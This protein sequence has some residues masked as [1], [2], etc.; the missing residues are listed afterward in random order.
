MQMRLLCAALAAGFALAGCGAH[1]ETE[2]LAAGVEAPSRIIVVVMENKEYGEIIGSSEAP[3][4]NALA[5][6]YS[7]PRRYHG[8]RH[9]SLPNYIALVAGSTLGIDSNCTRCHR[10]QRNL[11]DQFE[12]AG[13]SWRAYMEG[14]PRRCYR[15]ARHGRYAKKHNPFAYFDTVMERRARCRKIVPGTELQRDI[16]AGTLPEF[17][18]VKPDL[19]ND[20]HDC[21]IRHGDDYLAGLIP[22]LLREVGPSG[23][24]LLVW[25]EGSSDR[26]CCGGTARGGRVAAVVAGPRVRRGSRPRADLSHYSSLRTIEDFFGLG[27]LRLAGARTTRP[28]NAAFTSPPRASGGS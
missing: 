24:L 3:Y 12:R 5:R 15:G 26:G 18:F 11:V 9:P 23:F 2:R 25:E 13:V 4:V 8:I 16:D 10:P 28:L 19:C 14:M 20:T 21:S 7:A 22:P 27:H 6:K 17:A 1:A